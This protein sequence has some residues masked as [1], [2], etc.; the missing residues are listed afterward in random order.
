MLRTRIAVRKVN[1]REIFANVYT[2]A[3]LLTE[4]KDAVKLSL[5]KWFTGITSAGPQAVFACGP[6]AFFT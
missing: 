3:A 1:L 6:A 5:S 4:L 2:L